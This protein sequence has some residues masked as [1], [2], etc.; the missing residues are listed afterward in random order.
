VL[1]GGH[2]LTLDA[3]LPLAE[4]IGEAA[5]SVALHRT[6]VAGISLA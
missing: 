1:P 4:L 6:A 3:P 5:A 2:N